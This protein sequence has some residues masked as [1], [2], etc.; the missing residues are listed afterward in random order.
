[1]RPIDVIAT[2]KTSGEITPLRFRINEG[3]ESIVV[4]IKSAILYEKQHLSR[5]N[6]VLK[7]RCKVIVNETIKN[8]DIQFHMQQMRWILVKI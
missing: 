6:D 8:C 7:F 2:H 1:M 3:D 5:D 4:P